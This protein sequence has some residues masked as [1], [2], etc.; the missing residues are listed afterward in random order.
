M[1]NFDDLTLAVASFGSSNK[2]IFDDV[3]MPSIMVG[4]PKMKYSDLIPGGTQETLPFWIVDGVEK[5]VIWV[6][7]YQNIVSHDRAYSLPLCDPRAS[8]NFDQ[9]LAACRKKG[10]GVARRMGKSRMEIATMDRM[11]PARGKKE[12]W[13][14]RMQMEGQQERLRGPVRQLGM[15]ILPMGELQTL[16]GTYGSGEAV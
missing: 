3:G 9:A 1:G 16:K 12:L 2:V 13:Q 10:A 7:K 8:I 14:Q 6:S 5:D 15:M 4:V 11:M